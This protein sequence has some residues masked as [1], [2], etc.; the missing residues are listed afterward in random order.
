MN[1]PPIPIFLFTLLAPPPSCLPVAIEG[2][3][4]AFSRS[5]Y[6]TRPFDTNVGA[7]GTVL[8]EHMIAVREA[9]PVTAFAA[10]VRRFQMPFTA[11][12]TAH[13]TQTFCH[14]PWH[15]RGLTVKQAGTFNRQASD[16]WFLTSCEHQSTDGHENGR[17]EL[18]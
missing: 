15:S 5:D 2:T 7:I 4:A 13:P 10:P 11:K 6:L 1:S 8:D 17:N 16:S 9:R 18:P 3:D 12:G 14:S